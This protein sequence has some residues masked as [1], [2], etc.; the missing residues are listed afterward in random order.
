MS[1]HDNFMNQ[2]PNEEMLAPVSVINNWIFNNSVI[3]VNP[4]NSN[5]TMEF[6]SL[7]EL[8]A[9][10]FELKDEVKRL[11]A[12]VEAIRQEYSDATNHYNRPPR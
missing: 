6:K 8:N 9:K 10:L 3:A 5:D 7:D 12:E 4:N 1:K 11:K 2:K